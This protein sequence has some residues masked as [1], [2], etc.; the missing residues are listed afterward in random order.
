ESTVDQN[1]HIKYTLRK[2]MI[3]VWFMTR[4]SKDYYNIRNISVE[5]LFFDFHPD[6]GVIFITAGHRP[7]DSYN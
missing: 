4:I 3:N 5:F 6:R 1:I 7:A 2:N